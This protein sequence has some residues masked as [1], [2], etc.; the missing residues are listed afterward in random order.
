VTK[1]DEIRHWL[2]PG[3]SFTVAQARDAVGGTPAQVRD[4]LRRL[5]DAGAVRRVGRTA[6]VR[7]LGK[8]V[9]DRGV[10]VWRGTA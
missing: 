10:T 1:M 7:V 8:M 4:A 2:T 3:R 6:P 9:L 5:A